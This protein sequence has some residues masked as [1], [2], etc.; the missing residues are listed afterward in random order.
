MGSCGLINDA[1]IKTVM[2]IKTSGARLLHL[3]NDIL[4]AASMRQVRPLCV[5]AGPA[6][7]NGG[8]PG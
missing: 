3:I 4:D 7:G 1:A 2:T 8:T 6:P 5:H